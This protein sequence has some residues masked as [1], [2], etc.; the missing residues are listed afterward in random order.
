MMKLIQYIC[1]C[2]S[3]IPMAIAAEPINVLG[4]PGYISPELIEKFTADT[5]YRINYVEGANSNDSVLEAL[6]LNK[7]QYDIVIFGG[8][9]VVIGIR[10]GLLQPI[11][12]KQL[13]N[14]KHA[15]AP[16]EAK[17]ADYKESQDYS[18]NYVWGT[19]GVGY[20]AKKIRSRMPNAPID[21]LA[22][23]FDPKVMSKFKDC[24]IR[25]SSSPEDILPL[26][27]QYMGKNPANINE[28]DFFE[29]SRL[30]DSIRPYVTTLNQVNIAKDLA[31]GKYCLAIARSG[32]FIAARKM[33]KEANS[34]IDL[35]Y[36]NAKD[37]AS[38]WFNQMA[39][40]K[41]SQN[42]AG[43]H[44]FMNFIMDPENSKL[45]IKYTGYPTNNSAV[46]ESLPAELLADEMFM[47]RLSM[48]ATMFQPHNIFTVFPKNMQVTILRLWSQFKLAK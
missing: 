27:M 21:S 14:L 4:W 17:L 32:D 23:V 9:N 1:V 24:G 16:V 48:L 7:Q 41:D 25:F 33:A 35:R 45:L 3:I 11:D 30:L 22:M 42:V 10:D 6:R 47:P 40:P 39:I 2:M 15:W 28:E 46:M 12:K 44:A 26:I 43:A 38:A 5:G 19:V 13:P 8:D 34:D 29:I 36:Y 20:D 18:V 31:S 37:G